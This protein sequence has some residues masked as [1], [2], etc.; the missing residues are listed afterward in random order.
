[1]SNTHIMKTNHGTEVCV[2]MWIKFDNLRLDEA[3]ELSDLDDD[4]LSPLLVAAFK[5]ASALADT[6]VCDCAEYPQ[7]NPWNW[8]VCCVILLDVVLLVDG[9][10]FLATCKSLN[11]GPRDWSACTWGDMYKGDDDCFVRNQSSKS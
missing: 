9:M 2:I 1:M 11:T 8:S 3:L 6:V 5:V 7:S 10:A 4:E